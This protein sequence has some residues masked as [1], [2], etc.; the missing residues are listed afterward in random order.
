MTDST[1]F[2]KALALFQNNELEHASD[3]AQK[4]LE[5]TPNDGDAL[6]LL[7]AIAIREQNFE[8]AIKLIKSAVSNTPQKAHIYFCNLGLAH[9]A[10]GSF[11]H[12][13]QAYK[14]AGEGY[15]KLKQIE[16]ALYCYQKAAEYSRL[17]GD[18]LE[19]KKI[20][21][22][23][24]SIDPKN[25]AAHNDLGLLLYF[26]KNVGHATHCFQNAIDYDPSS[27]LAYNHLGILRLEAEEW[28]EAK[29][30]FEKSLSLNPNDVE[31]LINLGTLCYKQEQ[32]KEA[33]KYLNQALELDDGHPG[34]WNNLGITSFLQENID[35]ALKCFKKALEIAPDYVEAKKHLEEIQAFLAK[36][37]D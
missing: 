26:E 30:L 5:E 23:V 4:I 25:T 18:T 13:V 21:L 29:E 17:G 20:L 32:F 12:S 36:K 8:E 33:E 9:I 14:N 7:G 19:A 16:D 37:N 34:A 2:Q 15:L 22:K 35:K 3:I 6:N 10:N 24:L 11:T 27:P 28:S 31:T 1:L